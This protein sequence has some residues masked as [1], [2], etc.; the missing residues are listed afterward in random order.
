MFRKRHLPIDQQVVREKI[1]P[2][3]RRYRRVQHAHR[4]R[5]RASRIHENLSAQSFL[6][7]VQHFKRLSGHHH[8]APH[9]QVR[10]QLHL[11]HPPPPPPPRH[12]STLL[13]TPPT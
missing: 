5:R 11:L 12:H 13:T 3:R 2:P 6:L 1:Q 8:F 10:R 4:P 7:L 9:F